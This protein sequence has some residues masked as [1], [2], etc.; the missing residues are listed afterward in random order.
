MPGWIAAQLTRP[1]PSRVD[2]I[3]D[4]SGF[5]H[6]AVPVAAFAATV[7]AV[8]FALRPPGRW[9]RIWFIAGGLAGTLLVIAR[10]YL[11]VDHFT[12]G[13][14]A[15]LFGAALTTLVLRV[16][17]PDEAFPVPYDRE[18]TAHLPVT[19]ARGGAAPHAVAITAARPRRADQ[20]DG[21]FCAAGAAG[22]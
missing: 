10:L 18:R 15:A 6:P 1:R 3:G 13:V 14:F 22:L 20:L 9:R 21:A 7:T 11:G 19:G 5:S 8:G 2:I 17:A 16:V 4:W 12:D